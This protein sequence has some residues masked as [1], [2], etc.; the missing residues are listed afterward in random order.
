MDWLTQNWLWIAVAVGGFFLM[1]RMGGCGMGHSHG[2]GHAGGDRQAG[3]DKSSNGR[4]GETANLFDPVSQHIVAATSAIASVYRGRVYYFED[5]T[6]RDSFESDPEKYLVGAQV[7]G[8][9]IGSPAA[10]GK[11]KGH[12]CC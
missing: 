3:T 11:H 6:N 5:R 9:E 10:P 7:V 12:G 1:S 8:Q 4:G 2:G